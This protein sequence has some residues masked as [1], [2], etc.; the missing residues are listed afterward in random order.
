MGGAFTVCPMTETDAKSISAWRYEEKLSFYDGDGSTDELL[1][2]EYRAVY[3]DSE[4]IGFYCYGESA[5]VGGYAYD[6]QAIDMGLGLRPDSV[7]KGLGRAFV[8]KGIE[9]AQAEFPGREIRL[10]VACFNEVATRVYAQLGFEMEARFTAITGVLFYVMR[11]RVRRIL[12]VSRPLTEG[13]EVFSGHEE[14]H[15]VQTCTIKEH[16]YNL[17][18]FSMGAHCGTHMDAPAHFL[19]ESLTI[20]RVPLDLLMGPV[21]VV[22]KSDGEGYAQVPY[23]TRRLIVRSG[24]YSGVTIDEADEIIAKGV[25]LLGTD[26][27]SV[28]QNGWDKPVHQ[29]LL[30]AGVWI[31]ETLNLTQ[32]REGWYALSCLPLNIVG[33]EGAPA[34]VLLEERA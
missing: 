26:R 15:K 30:G 21:L 8:Q 27:L 24:K 11:R 10:T 23:G 34:R 9:Q 22:E 3:C 18:H 16:S 1:N 5:C 28:A 29:K 32:A 20:D 12:D 2:G 33:A 17:T 13:M 6:R 31:V 4:L 19:E 7:G 14:F 25:R